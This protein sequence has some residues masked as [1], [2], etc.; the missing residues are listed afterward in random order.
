MNKPPHPA[1]TPPNLPRSNGVDSQ[2][3]VILPQLQDLCIDIPSPQERPALAAKLAALQASHCQVLRPNRPLREGDYARVDI[4]AQ[5]GTVPI[6]GECR[7][8]VNVLIPAD[9]SSVLG[10]L[11]GM[12]ALETRT[13]T[14]LL[15]D[16][17]PYPAWRKAKASYRIRLQAI[18]TRVLPPLDD[19]L[20]QRSGKAQT[21]AELEARLLAEG[22][23]EST[24]TWQQNVLQQVLQAVLNQT[25]LEIP[26]AL[27]QARLEAVWRAAEVPALQEIRVPER[28]IQQAF[29]VWSQREDV[30]QTLEQALKEFV[31]IQAIVRREGFSVSETDVLAMLGPK[32]QNFGIDARQG[33]EDLRKSGLLNQIE[34]QLLRQQALQYLCQQVQLRFQ[35]QILNVYSDSA[36]LSGGP[37]GKS[38]FD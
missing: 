31:L 6:A 20:A 32:A 3:E 9:K 15:P 10:Q 16:D 36:S 25:Q 18:E 19:T 8:A 5:V 11:A 37:H 4:F 1:S 26:P 2:L 17:Y 38:K 7:Q 21:L 24:L 13:I 30:L 23:A 12:K 27:L 22:E 33:L 34:S 29:T 14:H 28:G 35:D